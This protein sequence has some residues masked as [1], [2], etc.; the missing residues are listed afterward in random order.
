MTSKPLTCVKCG[1]HSNL[2]LRDFGTPDDTATTGFLLI[3]DSC[4]HPQS[5]FQVTIQEFVPDYH[6]DNE[7]PAD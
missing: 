1:D 3:C 5:V 4:Y 7:L 6:S 2:L